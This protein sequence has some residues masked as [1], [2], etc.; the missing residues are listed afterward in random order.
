M[1][2]LM[3]LAVVAIALVVLSQA[4]LASD[5]P[6]SV[7]ALAGVSVESVDSM[8]ILLGQSSDSSSGGSYRVPRG[9]IRLVIFGVIALFSAGAWVLRKIGGE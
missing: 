8:P 7:P 1:Y 2:A 6:G 9:L 4:A 5:E 3:R